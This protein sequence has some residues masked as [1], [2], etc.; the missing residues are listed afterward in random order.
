MQDLDACER[1]IP[2]TREAVVI[3][4]GLI[5]VELVE[6]LL[7]H[8]VKTTFLVR[9]PWYWP[10]ALCEEEGEMVAA[11]LR[12]HGV[13]LRIGVEARELEVDADGRC[14]RVILSDGSALPAPDGRSLRSPTVVYSTSKNF[15]L[16]KKV[17]GR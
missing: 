11:H 2:S 1:W 15:A 16:L 7:H 9:E 12:A 13:D 17:G 10:A 14:A 3:G 5:G 6:C 4:G 8:G